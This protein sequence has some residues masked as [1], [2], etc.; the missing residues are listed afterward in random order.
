MSS[1][2]NRLANVRVR[3]NELLKFHLEK[4]LLIILIGMFVLLCIFR[5]YGFFNIFQIGYN[6]SEI[7]GTLVEALITIFA[8][9]FSI[10]LVTMERYSEAQSKL[11]ISLYFINFNFFIPFSLNFFSVLINIL[12]YLNKSLY[13]L[14]D[15]GLILAFIAILSLG[16]FF[17]YTIRFLIVENVVEMLLRN[18][19]IKD[20]LLSRDYS[21]EELYRSHL[22]PIE[23]IIIKSIN[24]RQYSSAKYLLDSVNIKMNRTLI[25]VKEIM[26]R[27]NDMD[28]SFNR[29]IRFMSSPFNRLYRTIAFY[30]NNSN[31]FE[32]TKHII[33]IIMALIEDFEDKRF[34]PAFL[35]FDPLIDR[36]Y[37]QAKESFDPKEYSLDLALL[38]V[39]IS[40]IRVK[41]SEYL[42]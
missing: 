21:E 40:D 3:I 12:F 42:E 36:I 39:L 35:I 22:Q 26:S 14:I 28:H 5:L 31:A 20:G 27:A 30:A 24:L 34:L 33:E 41:F 6:K 7:L 1:M 15:Y 25:K 9:V 29:Q 18:I 11:I 23:E 13:Y 4:I 2:N 19:K 16:V 8:I 38:G 17:Y 32:I 10:S 37:F